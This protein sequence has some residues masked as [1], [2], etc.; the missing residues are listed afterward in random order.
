MHGDYAEEKNRMRELA[1]LPQETD[2]GWKAGA[3]GA[4]L[5]ALAGGPLGAVIGG[6]LGGAIE[7]DDKEKK[8]GS[9]VLPAVAAGV[10]GAGLGYMAGKAASGSSTKAPTSSSS[11]T[12]GSDNYGSWEN[13]GQ[14]SP[15]TA[16]GSGLGIDAPAAGSMGDIAA[17][18]ILEKEVDEGE[19][20]TAVGAGLGGAVGGI[21]G[22]ALGGLAGHYL[23]KDK[24]VKKESDDLDRMSSLAGIKK[25]VADESLLA[26]LVG[27]VGGAALGGELASGIGSKFGSEVGGSIGQAAGQ[28]QAGKLGALVGGMKGSSAGAA[29]G[30]A[31]AKK[32]GQ[33]AGG[34]AGLAGGAAIDQ[35]KKSNDDE[36]TNEGIVDTIKG[37]AGI[38]P[39][40]PEPGKE[41]SRAMKTVGQQSMPA[42]STADLSKTLDAPNSPTA[43]GFSN[44]MIEDDKKDKDSSVGPAVAGA[45]LGGA[46]GY[47]A[48]G[49]DVIGDISKLFKGTTV[50]RPTPAEIASGTNPMGDIAGSIFEKDNEETDEGWK[51]QLAG[52]L[53]GTIGGGMAGA[54]LGGPIG[55]MIG[56]AAG[57]GAGGLLGD[58]LGGPQETDEGV[59]GALAGGAVGG[60]ATRSV[61]GAVAGAKLGSAIQDRFAKKDDSSPLAGQY[62]HS[63]KMQEVGK[64]TSFLDRLKELSGLKK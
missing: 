8:S 5:G 33:V 54:A 7:E 49:G 9:S 28:E 31:A 32:F 19:L 41:G 2:E 6:G 15:P 22:A 36:E 46:A 24:E 17:S 11:S 10:A 62:G 18:A 55:A 53:V 30:G 25:K 58:K 43:V 42:M 51:G 50:P 52:G 61:K 29:A 63:G 38:K 26:P 45:A 59:G 40:Q 13:P 47:T 3:L 64:D 56:S 23:T 12:T 34:I 21:G 37:L 14:P 57:G 48:A 27:A 1:G 60:Y 4:G 39:A 16:T 35:A 44:S 20:G